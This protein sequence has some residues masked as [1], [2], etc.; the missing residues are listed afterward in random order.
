M[1]AAIPPIAQKA[2]DAAAAVESM[3]P[4]VATAQQAVDAVSKEIA[5]ARGLQTGA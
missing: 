2:K 3:R 1:T 4:A 5:V